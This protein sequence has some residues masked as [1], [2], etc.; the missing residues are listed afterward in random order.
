MPSS[1]ES[2]CKGTEFLANSASPS[3][4]K[5]N[6]YDFLTNRR[7]EKAK[8]IYIHLPEPLFVKI[9]HACF[10]HEEGLT[11]NFKERS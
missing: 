3:L 8:R 2:G 11:A 9:F 1:R 5:A 7:K 10:R 4:P 6:S